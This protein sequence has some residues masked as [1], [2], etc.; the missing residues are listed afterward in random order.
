ME[1]DFKAKDKLI[2][3]LSS[4]LEKVSR[5]SQQLLQE[6]AFNKSCSMKSLVGQAKSLVDEISTRDNYRA[7]LN[8]VQSLYKQAYRDKRDMDKELSSNLS[9]IKQEIASVRK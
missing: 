3:F 7:R 6:D 2:D 4:R 1:V 5:S 8:D 9:D